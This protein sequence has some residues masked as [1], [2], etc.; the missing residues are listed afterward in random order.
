M[1]RVVFHPGYAG[2]HNRRSG[3]RI[4]SALDPEIE[5]ETK[6]SERDMKRD[7]FKQLPLAYKRLDRARFGIVKTVRVLPSMYIQ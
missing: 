1:S 5:A 6:A 7:A 3:L 2:L 4:P